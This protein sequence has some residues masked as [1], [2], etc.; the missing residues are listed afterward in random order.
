MAMPALG[1]AVYAEPLE[2]RAIEGVPGSA[3][4]SEPLALPEGAARVWAAPGQ[5]WLL[6]ERGGRPVVA[7]KPGT[8]ETQLAGLD[9]GWDLMAF[10]PSGREAAFYSSNGRTL[11]IYRGL[12]EAAEL[13]RAGKMTGW[14]ED[15]AA[16]AL[17]DGGQV[18][19][20]RAGS[21]TVVWLDSASGA[22]L[23]LL[24]SERAGD[25][26]FLSGETRL[27]AI[28]AAGGRVVVFGDP[29]SGEVRTVLT[30]GDGLT[31]PERVASRQA[32]LLQVREAARVWTIR[33]DGG[34][35]GCEEIPHGTRLESMALN[36]LWLAR[37]EAGEPAWLW[38]EAVREQRVT[39]A[40]AAARGEE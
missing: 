16:L 7:W 17:A 20:G 39:F 13:A 33:L 2:V 24:E 36:G 40:A 25:I 12:P 9:G 26:G 35:P 14:P 30:A 34:P 3:N 15:L 23:P 19:A 8:P 28:D 31:S 38:F 29:A 21:G 4:L 37:A 5:A 11:R 10:S 1:Y 6:V 27:A 32:G 22:A 18:L